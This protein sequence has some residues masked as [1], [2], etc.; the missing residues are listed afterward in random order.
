MVVAD[1]LKDVTTS[2][3]LKGLLVVIDVVD[4]FVWVEN[5]IV[6]IS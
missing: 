4:A 2:V 5:G 1:V 3:E 6:L